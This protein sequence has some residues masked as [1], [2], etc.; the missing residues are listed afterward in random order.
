M[1]THL[2]LWKLKRE[3]SYVGIVVQLISHVWLFATHELQHTTLPCPSL[4]PGVCVNSCPLSHWCYLTISSSVTLFSS[5]PESFPASGS[6]PMSQ[7]FSS[8]GQSIGASALASVLLMNIQGWF[9]FRLTVLILLFAYVFI[10]WDCTVHWGRGCVWFPG[11]HCISGPKLCP[12]ST[13]ST[14]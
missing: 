10:L 8:G 13:L 12:F 5:C 7:L 1:W 14:Q 2:H 6:Y 4:S 3:G 11:P 9:P